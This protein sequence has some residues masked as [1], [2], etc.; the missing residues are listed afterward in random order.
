[1]TI[2]LA[3]APALSERPAAARLEVAEFS[4]KRQQGA[5]ILDLRPSALFGDAHVAGSLNIGIA[6][7]SFYWWLNTR[8]RQRELDSS[9]HV[10]DL[11]R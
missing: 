9:W 2:N 11:M 3:G 4:A 5:T 10:L 7:P 6:S 1:M 8:Q